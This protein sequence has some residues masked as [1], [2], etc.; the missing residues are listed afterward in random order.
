M[1]VQNKFVFVDVQG[2]KNSENKFIP[3][4]ICLITDSFEFHHI[5]KTPCTYHQLKSKY[6]R[7]ARFLAQTFHGLE[8]DAAGT[9]LNKFIEL[10][11]EHM[12]NKVCVVKGIEKVEWVA[13]MYRPHTS[14]AVYT[15]IESCP[16]QFKFVEEKL[17]DISEI[18][19]YHGQ[20]ASE[21]IC[22]CALSQ[23]RQ[24]RGFFQELITN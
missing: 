21:M 24:L 15:N 12:Q 6:K 16:N 11:L 20:I 10:T 4:E 3:K 19:P 14:T 22:H 18:C 9:S 7:Q 13:S 23:A 17:S 5:L 2:F 1:S 8:F